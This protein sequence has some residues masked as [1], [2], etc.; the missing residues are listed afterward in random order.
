ML[1]K[2]SRT[3]WIAVIVLGV[4]IGIGYIDR[5]V[6]SVAI[7]AISKEYNFGPDVSGLLL[8]AFSWSY[9]IALVPAGLLIDRYGPKVVL[10]VGYILWSLA[11]VLTGLAPSLAMLLVCRVAL[12]V[13]EAPLYPCGASLA[14]AGFSEHNRG[15]ASAVYSEGAKIGPAI[16]APLAAGLLAFMG[17]REMF[18]WVGAGL[19][20]W[21]PLWLFCVPDLKSARSSSRSTQDKAG[22]YELLK[23]RNIL[24]M[25]LGNFGY[26]YAF[27][28]Y[29]T[30][31]PSYLIQARG[32][33]LVS[34]GLFTSL[35]F[36]IFVVVSLISGYVADRLIRSGNSATLVRKSFIGAGLFL[37]TA[38]IP[39]VLVQSDSAAAVLFCVSL[40]GMGI[41]VPNSLAVPA[42]IA[43]VGRG[44]M[45]GSLSQL[46]G[47]FGG[48]IAPIITGVLLAHGGSFTSGMMLAGGMLF[49][50]LF[51]FLVVL[52]DIQPIEMGQ[53]K[54]FGTRS[55][56][57][58]AGG[59]LPAQT[60]QL[61]P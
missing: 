37:A 25:M 61:H 42:G 24:G 22:W 16:G 33:G 55:D 8:A 44:A 48:A 29:L 43:P 23:Q 40:L 50:A 13:G 11:C 2:D 39:A 26:L 5:V 6:L 14:E 21:L 34:A 58:G 59:G 12:G 45:P 15:L 31:L 4:A 49:L 32:Y 41:S 27:W 47:N 17:W 54:T 3:S 38:I 56:E 57:V 52:K 20:I 7:P 10:S 28:V 60:T 36:T 53:R 18:M 19:L 1:A 9:F 35:P 51:G 30:W 46:A